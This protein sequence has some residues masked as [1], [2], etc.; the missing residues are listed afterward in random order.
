MKVSVV[1]PFY[2][3]ELILDRAIEG[4]IAN[5]KK[6]DYEWE[7]I[8]VND[9]SED[10]SLAIAEKWAGREGRLRIV[11][12]PI[13]QGRGYALK[14]GIDVASGDIIITTEIDLSWGDSI[15]QDIVKKFLD[16][17]HL[18]LVIAS[19]HLQGGGYKN[20]P[21][22]RVWLSKI[23]NMIIRN[24]FTKKVTMNTG[25]TRGYRRDVIKGI[26]T[27]EKG[28][29]FHLEVLLKLFVLGARIG[30]IPAVLE[31]K[32][33][34]LTKDDGQ[35]RRSSSKTPKLILSH[36]N[37]A[38]FANPIRYFWALS[39]LCI[40]GS[41]SFIADALYRMIIGKVAIYMALVGLFLGIFGLLFFGF[42]I[43]TA[44]NAKIMKELWRKD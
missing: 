8:I 37:F 25:M 23:G 29:E 32:D 5:L 21:F 38:V 18:D 42:G 31:W 14:S 35:K 6:L 2:N 15:V 17:P 41:L 39:L 40:I 12:Y 24:L 34:K 10:G 3:E 27:D 16:E 1:C 22:K 44:Q 19:P 11:S 20:V 28:K 30:E 13:N 43:V 9:G 26:K 7:L 36:L 33:H 4:L